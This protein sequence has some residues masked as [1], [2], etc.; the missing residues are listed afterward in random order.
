[1]FY[2]YHPC[3]IRKLINCFTLCPPSPPPQT[4]VKCRFIFF[5]HIEEHLT[6][7]LTINQNVT[8][9]A[10]N[11]NNRLLSTRLAHAS[12]CQVAVVKCLPILLPNQL[13]GI[14]LKMATW[15]NQWPNQYTK[16]INKQRQLFLSSLS[17]LMLFLTTN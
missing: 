2:D 10:R 11:H 16:A 5:Y 15:E 9:T 6:T 17:F 7:T 8:L 3:W 13:M 1:M 14:V 4:K 12:A